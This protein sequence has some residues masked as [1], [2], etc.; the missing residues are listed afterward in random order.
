M[1]LGASP[2]FIVRISP[3]SNP[4]KQQNVNSKAAAGTSSSQGAAAAT[5][6]LH[7]LPFIPSPEFPEFQTYTV[8]SWQKSHP[9]TFTQWS[10]TQL[11]KIV[12]L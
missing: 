12:N 6:P 11:F 9:S 1:F 5:G 7:A 10:T 4:A 2:I 8:C 3:T